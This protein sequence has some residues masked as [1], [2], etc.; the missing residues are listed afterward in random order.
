VTAGLALGNKLTVENSAVAIQESDYAVS[1][2]EALNHCCYES[3]NHAHLQLIL[4]IF[5]LLISVL[6]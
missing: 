6:F 1:L 3:L 4:H 5:S 2:L